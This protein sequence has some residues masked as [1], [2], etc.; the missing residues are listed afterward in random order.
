MYVAIF[1]APNFL[2]LD[3]WQIWHRAG[4]AGS[5]L[6]SDRDPSVMRV[7]L[8][9]AAG[10]IDYDHRDVDQQRRLVQEHCSGPGRRAGERPE[11]GECHHLGLKCQRF[12][13]FQLC[14]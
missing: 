10:P 6:F 12:V 5:G 1:T 14:R 8:G 3:H 11:S 2:D 7:N 9:F 13:L 4:D